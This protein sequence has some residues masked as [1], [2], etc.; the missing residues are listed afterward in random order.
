MNKKKKKKK[1]KKE[2]RKKKEKKEKKKRKKKK[3]KEKKEKKK[4]KRRRRGRRR[5]RRGRRSRRRRRRR[6]K[7]RRGRGRRRMSLTTPLRR[8]LLITWTLNF[9]RCVFLS[10]R[11][12]SEE[13]IM[14]LL[15]HSF[16]SKQFGKLD[17]AFAIQNKHLDP[18]AFV[19]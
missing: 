10:E 2:E 16:R 14:K 19:L 13:F 11:F 3:K 8:I 1:N 5:R 12:L 4:E 6:R 18:N 17:F 7:R 9:D 15:C